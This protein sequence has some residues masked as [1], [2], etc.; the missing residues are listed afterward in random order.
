LN[1]EIGNWSRF[2]NERQISAYVGL[3][4]S[5]YSSGEHTRRG[6]IIGQ[7]NPTL[8][9]LLIEASWMLIQKDLT[10]RNFFTRLK[11]QTGSAKKAIV[12]VARKLICRM[13]ATTG[14]STTLYRLTTK[15]TNV[16]RRF[17]SDFTIVRVLL[18]H[19]LETIFVIE[20]LKLHLT[21]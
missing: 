17:L 3:T 4:P 2:K 6:R 12:A 15:P 5:E 11:Y 9:S 19:N 16:L 21:E 13:Y 8:R 20:T 7:G 14:V 18:S 10:M 1:Y